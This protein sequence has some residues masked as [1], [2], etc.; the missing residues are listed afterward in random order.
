MATENVLTLLI[1]ERNK[2]NA[3][4][5]ALGGENTPA[6]SATVSTASA[7]A[8]KTVHTTKHKP[9]KRIISDE[10]RAKMAAAQQRRWAAVKKA[11]KKAA[12]KVGE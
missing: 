1:S 11:N 10:A 5:R 8:E 12:K 9:G 7:T 2:L 3:A 6:A 4:I